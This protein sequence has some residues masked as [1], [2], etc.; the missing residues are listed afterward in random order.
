MKREKVEG[1]DDKNHILKERAVRKRRQS[2]KE[3]H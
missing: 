2:L 3:Y 1:E